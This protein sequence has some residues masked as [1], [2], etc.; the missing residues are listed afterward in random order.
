[1]GRLAS[2]TAHF[3]CVSSFDVGESISHATPGAL[4]SSGDWKIIKKKRHTSWVRGRVERTKKKKKE[5]EKKKQICFVLFCLF[6]LLLYNVYKW[7]GRCAR[8]CV[9]TRT[10]PTKIKRIQKHKN[11]P[12]RIGIHFSHHKHRLATARQLI[13]SPSFVLSFFVFSFFSFPPLSNIIK[14]IRK[15]ANAQPSVNR[16]NTF[17][18]ST[19][20][21]RSFQ[22][23]RAMISN[24]ER[25]GNSIGNRIII[26]IK[27]AESN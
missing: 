11:K 15:F 22:N 12:K 9:S 16:E 18:I 8:K 24:T 5:V 4:F 13:T 1:M 6:F 2:I 25:E 20:H 19:T 7:K 23:R 10:F 14:P 21:S 17:V 27:G 3:A 26:S